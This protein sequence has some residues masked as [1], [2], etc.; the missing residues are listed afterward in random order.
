MPSRQHPLM[1]DAG[2]VNTGGLTTEE[3]DMLT[4]LLAVK[5]GTDIITGT[6]CSGIVRKHLAER[7]QRIEMRMV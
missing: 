5:A 2:H 3:N 4:L 6:A 7:F 1:Q